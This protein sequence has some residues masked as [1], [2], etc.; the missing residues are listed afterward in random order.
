MSCDI[1]HPMNKSGTDS[2]ETVVMLTV[3]RS[4]ALDNPFVLDGSPDNK[5]MKYVL[6]IGPR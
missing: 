1:N 6:L 4:S 2:E 5:L 3:W